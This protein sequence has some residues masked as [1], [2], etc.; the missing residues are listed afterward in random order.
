MKENKN[1]TPFKAEDV[2]WEELAAIGILKDELEMAGLETLPSV[3]VAPP[4]IAA[5][6]AAFECR[7][8]QVIEIAPNRW[9]IVGEP[10]A[11]HL[12][13]DAVISA[14][15]C[16]IDSGKLELVGRMRGGKGGGYS[17]QDSLVELPSLTEQQW[18]E[19][20]ERM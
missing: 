1:N 7:T 11:A 5:S 16:Y 19:R 14:K 10:L 9:L 3:H 20:E 6:P 18:R 8:K 12:R 15:D 17:L 2:N 13:D 4:R